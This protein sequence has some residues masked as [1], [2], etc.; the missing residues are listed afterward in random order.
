MSIP[1][2]MTAMTVRRPGGPEAL[3]AE[4]IGTP[5]PGPGEVL[6]RVA[7]AGINA[8]DL[9]QRRGLYPPPPGASPLLG[10]EVAGEIAALGDGATGWSTGDRVVALCNGGGYADYVAVPAAQVLP[11]PANWCLAAAAALPETFFTVMQTLV[12]R[13]GLSAGMHV[14]VHGAAGGIGGAALQLS[15][16]AGALPIGVVSSPEKAAYAMSLGAVATIDRR[17]EDLVERTRALTG[18]SGADRVVELA[19]GTTLEQSI[20]AS[21]RF[22]HIVQV[23]TLGGSEATIDVRRLMAQQLTLS[24]STLRPQTPQAKG[25]I[26]ARLRA[27]VWPAIADGR[28]R[29]PRV[30]ALPLAEA[31]RAHALMENPTSF[32]KIVLLTA[33]G[34]GDVDNSIEM[35]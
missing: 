8:P 19:G 25:A 10:L 31:G 9:A 3:M 14:L 15:R 2:E 29:Q 1:L 6:I 20:R 12:M 30:R 23:A 28:I 17:T 13:A 7:A 35:A 16:L 18:A 22:G 21:A 5:S 11:A 24:G 34:T 33:A 27:E 26:A 32:G 4:R